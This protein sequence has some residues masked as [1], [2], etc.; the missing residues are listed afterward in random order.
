[1]L[2]LRNIN[3]ARP[4]VWLYLLPSQTEDMNLM[5]LLNCLPV[6]F[7]CCLFVTCK[8][9]SAQR[10]K[11]GE[12]KEKKTLK[13]QYKD[14]VQEDMDPE[15][16]KIEAFFMEYDPEQQLCKELQKAAV[17]LKVKEVVKTGSSLISVPNQ[18]DLIHCHMQSQETHL[19]KLQSNNPKFSV[20]VLRQ[21]LCSKGSEVYYELLKVQ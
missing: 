4:I 12:A 6:I 11:S 20:V 14:F 7:L 5:K 16:L 13:P 10:Q 3:I 17:T 18:D 8:S 1:M 9:V 2:H 15:T 21:K 19:K